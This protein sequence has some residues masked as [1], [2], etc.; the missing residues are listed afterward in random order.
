MAELVETSPATGRV[1]G[2]YEVPSVADV[3]DAVRR[4]REAF[5]SWGRTPV[6]RRVEYLE[7]LR[8]ALTDDL[9]ATVRAVF[10]AH[11]TKSG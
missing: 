5:A 2:R 6:G 3:Q 9:D 11:D 4:S 1:V 7:R 8:A 10:S